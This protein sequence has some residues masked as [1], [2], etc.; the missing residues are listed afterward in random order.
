MYSLEYCCVAKVFWS[1]KRKQIK[2]IVNGNYLIFKIIKKRNLLQWKRLNINIS[3][4][5]VQPGFDRALSFYRA[6][7]K[8]QELTLPTHDTQE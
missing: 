6:K 5:T 2:P 3:D 4:I 7:S 8:N 1:S